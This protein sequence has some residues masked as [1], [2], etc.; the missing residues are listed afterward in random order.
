MQRDDLMF[1]DMVK[2]RSMGE[3]HYVLES[4]NTA[5]K[6]SDSITMRCLTRVRRQ[7]PLLHSASKGIFL[8]SRAFIFAI[9]SHFEL[10]LL[11]YCIFW[12]PWSRGYQQ[13]QQ[14]TEW[15]TLVKDENLGMTHLSQRQPFKMMFAFLPLMRKRGTQC[16]R[17]NRNLP[18]TLFARTALTR[19]AVGVLSPNDLLPGY[20]W[21]SHISNWILTDKLS[22]NEVENYSYLRVEIIIFNLAMKINISPC[23]LS[24]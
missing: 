11:H 2:G 20:Y 8:T 6:V 4:L 16:H 13:Q 23:D 3:L 14:Y 22:L 7:T 12:G 18:N 9:F 24:P 10:F 21:I 15:W 1:I 19:P 17:D 5:R